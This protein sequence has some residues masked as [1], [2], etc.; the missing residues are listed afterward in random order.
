MVTVC[1]SAT[2]LAMREYYMAY[3]REVVYV[4]SVLFLWQK[5]AMDVVCS[6]NSVCVSTHLTLLL[7]T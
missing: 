2:T 4:L 3:S 1:V 6:P 5:V 7:P